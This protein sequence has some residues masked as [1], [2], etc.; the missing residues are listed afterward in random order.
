MTFWH[1]VGQ[2]EAIRL[3]VTHGLPPG[4]C[5]THTIQ[6]DYEA[7]EQSAHPHTK[8]HPVGFILF[9]NN[10]R[11]I[12]PPSLLDTSV[13]DW[14]GYINATPE[15]QELLKFEASMCKHCA[16]LTKFIENHHQKLLVSS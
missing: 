1:D 5:S 10:H 2:V 16:W 14:V 6:G 3:W 8:S 7:A 15:Q 4:S 11:T 13:R 12:I 9:Y